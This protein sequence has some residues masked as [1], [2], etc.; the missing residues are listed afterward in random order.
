MVCLALA[1][2][3]SELGGGRDQL[4][5]LVPWQMAGAS[6][7]QAISSCG[8]VVWTLSCLLRELVHPAGPDLGSLGTVD[9]VSGLEVVVISWCQP[10]NRSGYLLGKAHPCQQLRACK[11]PAAAKTSHAGTA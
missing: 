2:G 5:T 6:G 4:V 10:D 11:S 3:C 9:E 7:L 1:P 8:L